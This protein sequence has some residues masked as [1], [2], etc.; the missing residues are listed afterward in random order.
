MAR[1]IKKKNK[2]LSTTAYHADNGEKRTWGH[3]RSLRLPATF[4]L[5]R[6]RVRLFLFLFT[7]NFLEHGNNA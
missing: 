4:L 5:V 3:P 1:Y 6:P 7:N 2:M